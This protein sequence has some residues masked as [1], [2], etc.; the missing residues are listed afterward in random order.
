MC[1]QQASRDV[2][3][4]LS[5][6][7]PSQ[8]GPKRARKQTSSLSASIKCNVASAKSH[9]QG[10][11]QEGS[12]P[13]KS[14]LVSWTLFTLTSW[15]TEIVDSYAM[16]LGFFSPCTESAYE[17]E[18]KKRFKVF[19]KHF[20]SSESASCVKFPYFSVFG[21]ELLVQISELQEQS[22]LKLVWQKCV[23]FV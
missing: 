5:D 18:Q 14:L 13:H 19:W 15:K 12:C 23:C 1:S 7:P 4:Q 16:N 22:L 20:S 11:W 17:N 3:R 10:H 9:G 8:P 6:R 2:A 21:I